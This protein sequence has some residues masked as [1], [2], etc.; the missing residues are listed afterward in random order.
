MKKIVI[1]LIVLLLTVGLSGC[2]NEETEK[3]YSI[4]G[5]WIERENSTNQ[6]IFREDG[7]YTFIVENSVGEGAYTINSTYFTVFT[8]FSASFKCKYR[9]LSDDVLALELGDLGEVIYDR[10]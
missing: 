6:K 10:R 9:F 7:T 4:V 5:T 3:N 8:N 2:T 1:P